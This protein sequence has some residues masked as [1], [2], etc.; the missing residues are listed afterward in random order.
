MKNNLL[1]FKIII[2]WLILIVVFVISILLIE[3]LTEY[4]FDAQLGMGIVIWGV[5][6]SILLVVMAGIH[7]LILFILNLWKR[8]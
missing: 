2:Y 1:F 7:N 5:L 4:R 8:H 6:V 3:G